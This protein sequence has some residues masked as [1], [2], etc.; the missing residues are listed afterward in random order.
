VIG[1]CVQAVRLD[2]RAHRAIQDQ[3]ALL[4]QPMQKVCT[5]LRHK[6]RGNKKPVAVKDGFYSSRALAAFVT[7]PQAELQIG[8]WEIL[9]S[10]ST[11]GNSSLP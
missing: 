10:A 4:E 5:V 6:C 8:A 9:W 3:D 7:R 11:V 2:H 1:V